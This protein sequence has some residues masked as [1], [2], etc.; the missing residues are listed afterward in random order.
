LGVI[1]QPS[2]GHLENAKSPAQGE[3]SPSSAVPQGLVRVAAGLSPKGVPLGVER[4]WRLEL[5]G[6]KW[7]RIQ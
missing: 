2:T 3:S 5:G 1:I 4:K 7:A 6:K